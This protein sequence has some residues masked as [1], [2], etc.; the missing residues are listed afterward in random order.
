MRRRRAHV[1]I[2]L[3]ECGLA[4]CAATSQRGGIAGKRQCKPPQIQIS[5]KIGIGTPGSRKDNVP[6][7][8]LLVTGNSLQLQVPELWN[9]T[10]WTHVVCYLE[11][12]AFEV[13][14]ESMLERTV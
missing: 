10:R 7:S 14:L 4:P 6:S 9:K 1:T 3:W 5:T 13:R 12:R 8:V 11:A 2:V